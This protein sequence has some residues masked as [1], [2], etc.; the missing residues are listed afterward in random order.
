MLG[1]ALVLIC[2]RG[3]WNGASSQS[4]RIDSTIPESS[5][6]ISDLAL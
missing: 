2:T 1:V 5:L 3:P 6:L 4:N